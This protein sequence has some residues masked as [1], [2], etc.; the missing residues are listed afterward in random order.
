MDE[1]DRIE[2]PLGFQVSSY[3]VDS[4]YAPAPPLEG[5][6]TAAASPMAAAG[7]AIEASS[8][9]IAPSGAGIGSGAA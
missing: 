2:N 7:S 9:G 1:K 4:D 8:A 5:A 6:D 3:R